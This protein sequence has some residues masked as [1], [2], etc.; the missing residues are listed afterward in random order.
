MHTGI[1][2]SIIVKPPAGSVVQSLRSIG[3][4]LKSAIA[5]IVDNSIAA[6]SQEVEVL[7]DLDANNNPF[8]YILD[9]GLGMDHSTLIEAMT[10]GTSS[11]SATRHQED[12]GRFGMGLKTASFSQC[13]ELVVI[14][15][16]QTGL[17]GAK[18]DLKY[19]SRADEWELELLDKEQCEKILSE[20]RIDILETCSGIVILAT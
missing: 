9:N 13:L 12:L 5:D 11:P 2:N 16:K 6:R 15:K 10:P 18:W 4:D 3:Y 14:S 17:V 20:Y 7:L 1:N 8:L 19:V